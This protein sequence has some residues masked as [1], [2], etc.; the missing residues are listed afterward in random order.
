[1]PFD[2]LRYPSR[3]KKMRFCGGWK[4]GKT[5]DKRNSRVLGAVSYAD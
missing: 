1:M 2:S 3:L 5:A 4:S